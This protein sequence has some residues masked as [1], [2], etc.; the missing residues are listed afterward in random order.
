MCWQGLIS[1]LICSEHA[2][3]Q[4]PSGTALSVAGLQRGLGQR[5]AA[6]QPWG[7]LN[8]QSC[9]HLGIFQAFK[10]SVTLF[11][12]LLAIIILDYSFIPFCCFCFFL[13]YFLDLTQ[14]HVASFNQAVDPIFIQQSS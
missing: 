10:K 9:R 5:S 14:T 11:K 2:R 12:H 13:F 3:V 6:S 4:G 1:N 8:G 7:A